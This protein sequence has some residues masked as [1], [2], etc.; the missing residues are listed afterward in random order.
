MD[1]SIK[2]SQE[3]LVSYERY[4]QRLRSTIRL[5]AQKVRDMITQQEEYALMELNLKAALHPLKSDQQTLENPSYLKS[6]ESDQGDHYSSHVFS[7]SG[8]RFHDYVSVI[9]DTSHI[10]NRI[11]HVIAI[12]DLSSAESILKYLE[13]VLEIFLILIN[14]PCLR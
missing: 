14:V 11:F 7:E 13:V 1:E 5:N 2:Q 4:L 3:N 10:A 12:Q 9:T 8:L 6:D